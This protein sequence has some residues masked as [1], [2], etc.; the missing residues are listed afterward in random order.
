MIFGSNYY[1]N[2]KELMTR[3][4]ISMN[5]NNTRRI[6]ESKIGCCEPTLRINACI[7]V[8]LLVK[9]ARYFKHRQLFIRFKLCVYLYRVSWKDCNCYIYSSFLF[10][11]F[12]LCFQDN[13]LFNL[14]KGHARVKLVHCAHL[15]TY[16][17][18]SVSAR[19]HEK[20]L[21]LSYHVTVVFEQLIPFVKG[22]FYLQC[23]SRN[24]VDRW[25][26]EK[27]RIWPE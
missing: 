13:F 25:C 15:H 23:V 7:C 5:W 20:A 21:S 17:I 27:E 2:W 19:V 26:V 4:N 18:A 1:S 8:V 6:I 12:V 22:S 9:R 11:R 14:Q 3:I 16:L 10:F 24:H